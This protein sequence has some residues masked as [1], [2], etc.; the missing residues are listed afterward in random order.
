MSKNTH[1]YIV[2]NLVKGGSLQSEAE[3][4]ITARKNALNK[5]LRDYKKETG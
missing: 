1:Y 5:A 3:Q 4:V 2:K